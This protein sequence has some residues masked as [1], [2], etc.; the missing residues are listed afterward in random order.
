MDE[1]RRTEILEHD[2]DAFTALVRKA[3]RMAI[4][5]HYRAGSPIVIWRDGEK[6]TVLP[7]EIPLLLESY[8]YDV[9]GHAPANATH[10]DASIPARNR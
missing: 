9:T 8:G 2:N 3:V 6:V 7:E 4:E 1:K 10:A 5:E